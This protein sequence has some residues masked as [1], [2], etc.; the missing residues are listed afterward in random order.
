[1]VFEYQSISLNVI[2]IGIFAMTMFA[3][4]APILK[5]EKTIE[6]NYNLF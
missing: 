2:A 5:G 1:M 6:F 3:L 4:L